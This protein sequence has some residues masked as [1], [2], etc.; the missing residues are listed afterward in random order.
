MT[1][2]D[3]ALRAAAELAAKHINDRYMPDKAIDVVDEAGAFQRL[4]LESQRAE[5]ID[6]AQIEEVIAKIARI[7]T[8]Q[9]SSSDKE[10]LRHLERDLR[11][12]VFGQDAAT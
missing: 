4:Q 2:T 8:R 6:V 11:L 9:V 10:Q 7:P 5:R 1:Y 12:T 3:A